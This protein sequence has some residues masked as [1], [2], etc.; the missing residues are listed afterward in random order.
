MKKILKFLL[1]FALTIIVES[2]VCSCKRERLVNPFDKNKLRAQDSA[3]VV[4]I[5]R[6]GINP[7]FRSV[8]ELVLFRTQLVEN[9]INDSLFKAIPVPILQDIGDMCIHKYGRVD[10]KLVL[11][12][13]TTFMTNKEELPRATAIPHSHP[14]D[15]QRI[16]SEDTIINGKHWKLVRENT[17]TITEKNL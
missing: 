3:L 6:D 11:N 12:E 15:T 13:Y 9:A 5:I 17:I 4:K 7:S 8:N 10:K 2:T 16:Q 1:L 14:L